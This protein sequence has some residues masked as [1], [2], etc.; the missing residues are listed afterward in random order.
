MKG[1]E[2]W[3]TGAECPS[4]GARDLWHTGQTGLAQPVQW[5]WFGDG[6]GGS[7]GQGVVLVVHQGAL[8]PAPAALLC[9]AP[10]NSRPK[11]LPN[12]YMP[13]NR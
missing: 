4:E 12:R 13:P 8:L 10:H 6:V 9:H 3:H 1:T 11:C 7:K 2:Q 5:T